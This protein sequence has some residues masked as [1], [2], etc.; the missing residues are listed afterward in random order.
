VLRLVVD[1]FGFISNVA[2]FIFPAKKTAAAKSVSVKDVLEEEED[3]DFV[4]DNIKEDKLSGLP[5]NQEEGTIGIAVVEKFQSVSI[6]EMK[7]ATRMAVASGPFKMDFVH[8]CM[9]YDCFDDERR[10][11]TVDFL[12]PTMA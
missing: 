9:L 11:C 2:V 5:D 10:H 8:P 7:K 1:Y 12:V 4:E 6:L 3:E